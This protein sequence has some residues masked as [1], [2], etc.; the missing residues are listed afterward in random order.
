[1]DRFEGYFMLN[2]LYIKKMEDIYIDRVG[3]IQ[4]KNVIDWMFSC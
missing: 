3:E 1:M 2:K 4:E